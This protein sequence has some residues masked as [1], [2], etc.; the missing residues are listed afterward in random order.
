MGVEKFVEGMQY[1]SLYISLFW[2]KS[3]LFLHL[4]TPPHSL[5]LSPLL[6]A[7]WRPFSEVKELGFGSRSCCLAELQG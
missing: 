2:L 3:V 7:S 6:G 4:C 1:I 5:T